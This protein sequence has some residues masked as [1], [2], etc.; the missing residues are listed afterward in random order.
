MTHHHPRRGNEA[1]S[2]VKSFI[3]FSEQVVE[4]KTSSGWRSRNDFT[5]AT[6]L[7]T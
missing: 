3:N 1:V 7:F 2:P 6:T 5:E 4:L